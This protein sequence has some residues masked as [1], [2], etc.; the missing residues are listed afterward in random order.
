MGNAAARFGWVRTDGRKLKGCGVNHRI[1]IAGFEILVGRGAVRGLDRSEKAVAAT[2]KSLDVAGLVG[3]VGERRANLVDREIDAVLEIHEGGTRP[4]M[5]ADFLARN[6]GARALGEKLEQAK[7]LRLQ[8]DEGAVFAKLAGRR[9]KLKGTEPHPGRRG[10]G[11]RH[12]NA[13]WAKERTR[14]RDS[15]KIARSRA[16]ILRFVMQAVRF[17]FPEC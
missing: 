9:I 15:N 8:A 11:R 7:R 3:V 16:R 12:K 4:K 5:E 10:R 17:V 1:V 14:M 13:T 6:N 2:G